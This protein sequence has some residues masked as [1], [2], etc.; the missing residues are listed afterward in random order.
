MGTSGVAG[1]RA[2]SDERLVPYGAMTAAFCHGC[3]P[4]ARPLAAVRDAPGDRRRMR[5][6][7]VAVPARRTCRFLQHRHGVATRR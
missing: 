3:G 4:P 6:P 7:A 2:A 5:R 1:R